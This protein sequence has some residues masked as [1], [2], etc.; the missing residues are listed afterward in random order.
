M[1]QLR[2][3]ACIAAVGLSVAGIMSP[4]T[5]AE[6]WPMFGKGYENTRATSDTGISTANIATLSVVRRTTDGGITGT[7]T[8]VDGVAY[9][10]DFSGYVKAVRVSDGVV[11]WRVRPQ[12]T[13]LS[14]SPFVTADTVYVAGNNSYVYALNR[15]NGAVR[16]TT[17]IETSPNSRI[18]SSPI[19][20]GNILI[21]GT[22]SYQVFIPATPMFR[23]RV[24]FLNATTG[25]I[26]P[27][28]TNMCPSASCGGGISVWSTAAI[29]EAART[30]YIGTG[31]AYRDPAGPYSDAL[32]AFNIDTGAIRWA[33][34]FVA[35]DV[36]Q[37]Q[38]TLRYDYDVGAA[39][40]LFVANGQ[41]M[42]GVGGKD[43][44]YRA[45]NRDTGAPIWSTPVGQGSPIGGVMQSTAYGDG[46]IYVT[47]NTSTIGSGRNDP[48]PATSEALALDAATGTPVWVRQLDAGGFGGVAYANGLM[49]SSTWDGRL[50]VFNAA[51]GNLVKEVQVSPARGAYVPAPTDGF[52]NGS[53]GG[54][55]VYG[56]R[57]LM[58]Y[59]WTWVLNINGGLTTME[60]TVGGGGT[61]TVTLASS[62]DTYV[63]SGTPTTNY[64]YNVNLLARLADAEGLTRASFLQ[65]PLTAI[66]A[67]TITSARLR[68]YGRHD[69]T[70]GTG[71]S[72]SVWPGT[73]TTTW[74]G[75]NVT[76]DNSDTETGVDFYNTS[77]IATAT[78]GITP[79]YYEWNVTDYV[80][81]RRSLGHATFGLAVDSAHQYRVTFNSAD[82]TANRPELVV[83]VSGGGGGGNQLPGSCPSGFTAQAG[84]NQGFMHNGVARGFVLNV[85]AN[86]STPRP[87]FVSLTGSVE[88]TNENLG[89]RGGTSALTSDGFLVIG[90][91]R[92]C[93]GQDP[94]G[95]GTSVNGGTCNQAGTGG[96]TWN[97]WNEGRVFATAGDPWKTAE[98]PD[99]QFLEAVVRCVAGS[100]PVDSTRMYLGGI[101]SGGTMTN[102]ALLFNSDFW[103]G[104]LPISGE[105]YVSQDNGTAYPGADEFA[106]RRQAVINNPTKIFQGRVG[107]LPLPASQSPM[108]VI[109]VWGGTNDVWYC[110]STLC[111]DYRPSTQAASNYFSSLSNVVHVACSSSYGHQWPTQNRAAFNTWA[112]T[113]LASHPK[114]APASSFVLPPPPAGYSC[115]IGRYTDHY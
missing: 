107:P 13:M 4:A 95:S 105:W 82:N 57:V 87:V 2:T 44:T 64:A 86:T 104:G 93:A 101:S 8:V 66:P 100:Y 5:A 27:Y 10:S 114:G 39:P 42:V 67:G 14:P 34:Q 51:N 88:S 23:G 99:S 56:N 16:W 96:W 115:R 97:P 98:G 3:L 77:S 43:G 60:A 111:A 1:K 33:R 24:A 9:Y 49:Y 55:V 108:I 28:S 110:G 6:N 29:D 65:F 112:A 62:S 91:V 18:S 59:G 31:Q 106:A 84:V 38:G 113:T 69:A 22:G 52:P 79:Q 40:N 54:P 83:T 75:P 68:I 41:R 53:A 80:A 102:R 11:L 35:N 20:V 19:V 46:R 85:P 74:S 70:T 50:R 25:A 45:F 81:S 15:T 109:S 17:Q 37:L 61:Q 73:R 92:R 90:P 72:V 78:V 63:Q 36:Y 7:P 94:N 21:I 71:Q 48:V 12:T 26:L 47:S 32:V 58:G 30:G 89:A 76:Y 103:A